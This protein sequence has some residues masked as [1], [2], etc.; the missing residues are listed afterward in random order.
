VRVDFPAGDTSATAAAASAATADAGA[1]STTT[2]QPPS[3]WRVLVVDDAPSNRL[4]LSRALA[5]HLPHAVLLEADDGAAAVNAVFSDPRGVDVV[6][7]D[8]EMPVMD[9]HAATAELRA[10]GFG[11]VIVGVTGDVHPAEVAAFTRA[12]ADAVIGKPV[13]VGELLDT[14]HRA[15]QARGLEGGV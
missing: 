3:R 9:G 2:T 15:L 12:G 1:P 4:L 6:C 14:I 13:R 11:G 5:R 10:R 7:M 8:K